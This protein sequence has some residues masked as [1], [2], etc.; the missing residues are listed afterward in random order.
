M[1]NRILKHD[2][3]LTKYWASRYF[4]RLPSRIAE[5]G[6]LSLCTTHFL[7]L[8]SDPAVTSNAL[9]IRIVFPLVGVTPAY[10]RLGL[11]A[12]PGKQKKGLREK[13]L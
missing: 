9:A 13:I 8:P 4:G 3:G 12:M 7:S 5:S 2:T 10:R 11:P 1:S 6:S